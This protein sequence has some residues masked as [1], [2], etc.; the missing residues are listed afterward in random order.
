MHLCDN[1]KHLGP[2][3]SHSCFPFE[4]KNR[5]ILQLIH[6]S[7]TIEFQLNSAANIIQAIP[8]VIEENISTDPLLIRFYESMN[9]QKVLQ[10][11]LW[12]MVIAFFVKATKST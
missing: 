11:S 12:E 4:D 8:E 3:W 7:Q 9:K 2:P 10:F 5:F 1:V 6:G